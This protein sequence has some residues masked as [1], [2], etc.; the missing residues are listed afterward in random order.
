M[1]SSESRTKEAHSLKKAFHTLAVILGV[2]CGLAAVIAPAVV[3]IR[4]LREKHASFP[5]E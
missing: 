3:L 5:E 2:I 1:L 4:Y